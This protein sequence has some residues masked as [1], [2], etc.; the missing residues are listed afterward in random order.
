M[1]L[2]SVNGDFPKWSR[3]F[4][5]FSEFRES[6]KSLKHKLG[7]ISGSALLRVFLWYSG[8]ISVFYTRDSGF[9]YSNLLFF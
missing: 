6:E 7:S 5:E 4:I 9:E 2:F 3:T 1:I 8:I